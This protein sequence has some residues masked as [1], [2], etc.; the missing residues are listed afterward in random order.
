M[1]S[2]RLWILVIAIGAGS[3]CPPRTLAQQEVDPDHFDQPTTTSVKSQ[4][5]ASK[6]ASAR[7]YSQ[8]A[9]ARIAG[10][11]GARKAHHPSHAS[12]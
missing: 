5:H 8:P 10:K 12:A 3:V 11:R 4:A 9:Q 2:F 1:K 6:K 7:H